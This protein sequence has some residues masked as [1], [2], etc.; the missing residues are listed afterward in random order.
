MP[1]NKHATRASAAPAYTIWLPEG[2]RRGS[3]QTLLDRIRREAGQKSKEIQKIDT[4]QYAS[5]IISDADYFLPAD[6]L[7]FLR[8]QEYDSE[9][10]RALRYLSE[11]PGSG[12][13]ILAST[14]KN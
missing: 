9:F 3:A 11:M 4:P 10:D 5:R 13:R 2:I 8:G 12:V 7:E 6:L 1:S 14:S